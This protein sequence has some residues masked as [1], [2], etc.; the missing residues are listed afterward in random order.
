MAREFAAG[1]VFERDHPFTW[2]VEHRG[3]LDRENERWRPGA[4][5]TKYIYPDSAVAIANGVG[6]VKFTVV[7]SH[8]PPGYP[9]R[10]FFT[11]Q[12]FQPDGEAYASSKLRNCI[13]SKFAKDIEKFPFEYEVEPL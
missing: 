11:R 9:T 13:A 6:R 4:W 12:F 2:V 3:D 8:R 10:V 5:E 1:E 7:S